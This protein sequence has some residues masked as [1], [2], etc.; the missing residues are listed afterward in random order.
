MQQ[1]SV[2]L[3]L[4]YPELIL[5]I[6]IGLVLVVDLFVGERRKAIGF[7]LSLGG[8]LVALGF[9][10]A[11][12]GWDLETFNGSYVINNFTTLAKGFF[13]VVAV[14]ILML[15]KRYVKDDGLAQ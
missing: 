11:Q 14:G 4:L 8:V 3:T 7:W 5:S 2:N 1:Q 12:R 15:S 10:L 13:L 6:T 9:V